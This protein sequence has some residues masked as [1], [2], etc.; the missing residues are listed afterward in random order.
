VTDYSFLDPSIDRRLAADIDASEKNELVAYADTLG[1][2]TCGRGHLMPPA[3]P[4]RSWAG[5]TIIQSTSDSWFNRDLLDAIALAKKWA[6]YPKC[7]TQ[8]RV[9]GLCEIAFNMA[10]KWG[11]FVH[12]RA[13]IEAQDWQKVH[14][15]LL[16]SLWATQVGVGTFPDGKPKR[17]TRI[18]DQFL[19]GEYDGEAGT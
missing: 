8:A 10:G 16:N 9:N 17:A 14:D 3:A 5:F 1:N 19:K 7:D 4:G 12:A 11:Q 13:A 15:E 18:A 6:E 2:W